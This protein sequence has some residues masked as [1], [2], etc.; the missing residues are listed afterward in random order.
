VNA[1]AFGPSGHDVVAG[2]LDGSITIARDG[3]SHTLPSASNGID[4]IAMLD[5]GRVL[6]ADAQRRL[7]IYRDGRLVTRLEL[8]GRVMAL[9]IAGN[10]L[11]TIPL[12]P[13][14]ET[15]NT[16]PVLIDLDKYVLIAMLA[17]HSDRVFSARWTSARQIVT[18]GADGT[19]KQW[20]GATGALQQTYKTDGQPVS[21]ATILDD[22]IVV[23]GGGDGALRFWDARS[24]QLLWTLQAHATRIT[25]LH[26]EPTGIVTRGFD[27]QVQRW[28]LP[29]FE[30][31]LAA[32]RRS[33]RC[34]I[35]SE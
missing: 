5:D 27:G 20:D 32:C 11:V 8:P 25:G 1:V 19:V 12:M 28:R 23:G 18:A 6:A 30:Q 13:P 21:D 34:A 15:R 35:V 24:G 29:D 14:Y 31:A 16:P 17:G 22:N 10:R 2:S 3:I 26:L 4:A 7:Q 33:A 9:R